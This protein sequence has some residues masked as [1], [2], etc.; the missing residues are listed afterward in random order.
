MTVALIV[1]ASD[2]QSTKGARRG[3]RAPKARALGQIVEAAAKA[4]FEP[5]VVLRDEALLEEIKID[6]AVLIDDAETPSEASALRVALDFA[7]RSGHDAVIVALEGEH[8]G[9]DPRLDPEAWAALASSEGPV[10]TSDGPL[11]RLDAS[12]WPL[13]PLE[14]EV[15]RAWRGRGDL[16]RPLQRPSGPKVL[17]A[18]LVEA[19]S[20]IESAS[21]EDVDAVST[22]L[23]RP[24]AGR[25]S[26][27]VRGS[28]GAPVVIRNAPL[29]DDGTPMPTRYWLVGRREREAVGR[30]ES[31]GAV[32]AAEAAIAPDELE[33]AHRR[34]ATDRDRAIPPSWVGPRPT[35]GVGGTRVGVKC[36]HAHYA[37]WL[38]GGD[39]PVGR[40]VDEQ[41]RGPR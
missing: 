33:A 19:L 35:G 36:L 17:D 28:D 14:G 6:A 41:L 3:A 18:D 8:K 25:F 20:A 23:G 13:V 9:A 10:V 40:Y 27:V 16:V 11:V 37:W 39:D 12:T 22:L 5:I 24:P 38:A 29:L 31:C 34:Y 30:L 4:S 1:L 32:R 26:V 2:L 21:A 7:A 15:A